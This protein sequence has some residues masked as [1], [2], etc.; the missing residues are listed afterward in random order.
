MSEP[1]LGQ[2]ELF[3]FGFAPKG[4]ALCAGQIM[5]I[6]QNQAL[7]ALL[8]TTFGGNGTTTFALPD[9]RSR[10]PMGQGNG[11]GLTPRTLGETAG[12]ETHVL[13]IAETPPHVHTVQA[14]ANP[15]LANNVDAPG[16]T[17]A[18]AQTTGTDKSGG[19]LV[20][21]IYATDNAPNQPL[22]SGA[23]GPTGGQPHP[24]QMP[25]LALNACI[26]LVGIF[27]TRN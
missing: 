1:Y 5:A 18:L 6:N 27:P 23:I 21:N 24:N 13:S 16:P 8:G 22:A 25:Y 14:I 19:T 3:S 9:L 7:F 4:W 20:V 26:A 11:G 15:V 17:V 2:I 12:E 10:V